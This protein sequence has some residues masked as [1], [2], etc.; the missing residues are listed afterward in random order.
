MTYHLLL[1]FLQRANE[2]DLLPTEEER[3]RRN[4]DEHSKEMRCFLRVEHLFRFKILGIGRHGESKAILSQSMCSRQIGKKS[5][6]MH[7]A[8]SKFTH[9]LAGDFHLSNLTMVD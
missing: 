3:D 2:H 5:M 8:F 1:S 9:T 7:G 4:H 6:D